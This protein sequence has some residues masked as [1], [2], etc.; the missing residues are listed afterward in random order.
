MNVSTGGEGGWRRTCAL[1]TDIG[2]VVVAGHV[3][4]AP[5][6]MCHHHHT[7]LPA[8]EEIVWL[9]LSPVL[10]LLQK[11]GAGSAQGTG[12]LAQTLTLSTVELPWPDHSNSWGL[13]VSITIKGTVLS[14]LRVPFKSAYLWLGGSTALLP[15]ASAS[16]F[17]P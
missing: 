6:L 7:V 16:G 3:V 14:A 12:I 17:V 13:S 4:P 8:R 15:C 1:F 2:E 9:V 5:T 11:C 10:I